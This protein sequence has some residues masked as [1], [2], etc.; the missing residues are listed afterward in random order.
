MALPHE[1]PE[2][3]SSNCISG[4][5]SKGNQGG[6][7]SAYETD[8]VIISDLILAEKLMP[9]VLGELA[10]GPG[11]QISIDSIPTSAAT[12]EASSDA[13]N[14]KAI[15]GGVAIGPPPDGGLFAWSQVLAGHL[16]AFNAWGFMNSFGIFQVY[17]TSSLSRPPADISWV[18]GL[19][20]FMLLFVGAL[21]G[22]ALD[23]GYYRPVA[24]AG[25]VLQVLG[26]MMSSL[27]TQYW[28][29]VLAMGICQG[30]GNGLIFTPTMAVVSTYFVKKR[31]VAIMGMSSGTA[32]GGIVFPLI[33]RQLLPKIGYGWTVRIMGFI[34]IFNA[35]IALALIRPR[36][37]PR[38]SGPII[39]LKSFLDPWYGCC[40]LGLFLC[41][42]GM[43]F[44]YF[45]V[46][47]L[48]FS[49]TSTS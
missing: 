31:A 8:W 1:K 43:Y 21:S 42:L 37:P 7:H 36:L 26:I 13:T 16:V 12:A 28:Q 44:G 34:F 41:N 2:L 15:A 38:K 45:Y 30:L 5:S 10:G 14:E 6:K 39:E 4:E 32:S 18:G 22:R 3:G 23:A 20:I 24:V 9:P 35:V 19:Q 25:C 33:A 17:L 49:L 29:L 46:S 40:S 47:H 27:I 11:H 48:P